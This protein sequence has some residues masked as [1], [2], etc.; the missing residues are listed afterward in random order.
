MTRIFL[1]GYMGSGKS[2]FGKRIAEHL[3]IGFLDLDTVIESKYRQ[4]ISDIFAQ[5]GE[6]QFREIE[7]KALLEIAEFEDVIIA[8]GGGTPCFFDNMQIMNSCGVTIYF[9][10][11]AEQLSLRL[12]KTKSTKRP[13]IAHKTDAELQQYIASTL[14]ERETFYLQATHIVDADG[15]NVQ[16]I[17]AI[18]EIIP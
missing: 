5:F 9:R 7:H 13:L 8:T 4:S 11:T 16:I 6:T 2:F 1:V 14:A 12:A 18:S 15:S 17:K 3:G 10:L